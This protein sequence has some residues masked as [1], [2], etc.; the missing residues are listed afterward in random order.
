MK[1][2]KKISA[3]KMTPLE[4]VLAVCNN[5][6]PDRVPFLLWT[7]D[8]SL[9]QLGLTYE[10]IFQNPELYV[11][12]QLHVQKKFDLDGV[13]D[14]SATPV[15]DEAMGAKLV[16]ERNNPPWIHYD[17]CLQNIRDISKLRPIELEKEERLAYMLTI[18]KSLRKAVGPD[19]PVIAWTSQPF[20]TAC[21]LR[22]EVNLYKDLIRNPEG[23]KE[24]LD[25]SYESLLI[26]AKGLI[27]AGADVLCTSN[28][29]ANMDCISRKHFLEFSHLYTKRFFAELKAY[30]AKAIL[31]HICGCWNDRLDL[32]ADENVNILHVDKT[33]IGELKAK[34]GSKIVV[35][36]NVNTVE[37]L[38]Q[39]SSGNVK[40]EAL[41]CLRQGASDKK[42][43]LSADCVVPR[44]TS[45]ENIFAMRD[46][47]RQHSSELE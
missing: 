20:R 31:Y 25:V 35:M 26:Y 7:R 1:G 32:V 28:P 30:G 14:I 44:D 9:K 5:E 42:F 43:I 23:V 47:I 13:Y 21:M 8:F 40:K 24:L 4:R 19:V 16:I 10:D 27:D 18:V 34:Y 15:V 29:V 12:A 11:A 41:E 2:M 39:G 33:N 46:A 38:L 6:I 45:A 3:K 22:G 17:S 37:T 36:G